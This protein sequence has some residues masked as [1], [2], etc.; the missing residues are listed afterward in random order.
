[1]KISRGVTRLVFV[2]K[3]RVLKVPNPF[4][5][6][7]CFFEGFLSN[8][9]EGCT[10]MGEAIT[11]EERDMLCPVLAFSLNGFWL[12]MQRVDRVLEHEDDPAYEPEKFFTIT[13]DSKPQNFGILDG[14]TVVIDYA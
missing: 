5:G 4:N 6:W 14:R 8:Y 10:W 9:R 2:F 13:Q 7:I 3:D 12:L 1:M 11:S